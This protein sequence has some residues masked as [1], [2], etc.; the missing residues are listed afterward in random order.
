MIDEDP[1]A[2]PELDVPVIPS[3][4]VAIGLNYLDHIRETGAERPQ[5]PLVF[6]KFPSSLLA[7]GGCIVADASLTERIDWE[8]ELA[9][10]I[11]RR[12]RRILVDA[13]LDH[14][15]GYTV[16]NDVSARD[17]QF[18]DGQWV[19]GKSF[20]TFCPL[21]PV[22]VTADE[23]GDPQGLGLRT[24]VNGETVQ[25]S[26][27]REM[28]FGVAELISFCSH[29]FTLEPGDVLLTGTPWGCGEFA[30]PRR[31]LQPGDVVETE[32]DGIGTLRNPVVAA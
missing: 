2:A 1:L 28:L 16:G 6:T 26:S 25:D 12:A 3:K 22:V 14:V 19:R 9:V 7:D 27:T 21:G 8:V 13:A 4:V 15:F 11:G 17:V 5:A 31:S 29:S 30:T 23:I 10:V 32:I 18:S 24:R 20:D